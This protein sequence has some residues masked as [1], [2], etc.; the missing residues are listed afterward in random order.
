MALET[1][2]LEIGRLSRS[3]RPLELADLG[4]VLE[5]E[6][7]GY[8]HPWSE[9][10]F[11]DCFRPDYRLWAL[12]GFE[13]LRG[14]AIVAHLFDEAHLLNLCVAEHSRRSGAG[15]ML[16]RFLIKTVFDE[17]MDRLILEV[18][19]SNAPAIALYESEGFSVIGERPGYYPGTIEREDALVFAV[20]SMKGR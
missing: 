15:R 17:G 14:Y 7:T 9:G 12:T 4:D 1:P 11:R 3:I 6:R 13:R 10:V 19:R 2:Y 8:S 5:I 20:E 16:L 18:R